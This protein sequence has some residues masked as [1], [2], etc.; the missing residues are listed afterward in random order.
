ML[1]RLALVGLACF[2]LVAMP[3]T[4]RTANAGT[5]PVVAFPDYFPPFHGTGTIVRFTAAGDDAPP[6]PDDIVCT[7]WQD[8]SNGALYFF[9]GVDVFRT[10]QRMTVHGN[11]CLICYTYNLCQVPASA[12]MN[13]RVRLQPPG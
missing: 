3:G 4:T 9:D 13:V 12:L 11:V 6:G 1:L 8:D 7:F 5:R 2:I 10:G